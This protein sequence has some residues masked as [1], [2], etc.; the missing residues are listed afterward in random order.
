MIFER[1][2]QV[3][4]LDYLMVNSLGL[5]LGII[6]AVIITIFGLPNARA[7][8]ALLYAGTN[9]VTEEGPDPGQELRARSLVHRH[10]CWGRAGLVL[11]ILSFVLQLLSNA[12]QGHWLP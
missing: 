12:M 6:G 8:D 5:V 10:Q 9:V 4:C 11:L 1:M 3:I 2:S 7:V